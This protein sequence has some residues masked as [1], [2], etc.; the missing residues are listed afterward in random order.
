MSRPKCS[1]I[2][3]EARKT[4][5]RPF[6]HGPCLNSPTWTRT[7]DL[8][9]NSRSLYQLSYRGSKTRKRIEAIGCVK[10]HA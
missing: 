2:P 1:C 6:G 8:A 10:G 9:V 7:K 5:P 3:A 4:G